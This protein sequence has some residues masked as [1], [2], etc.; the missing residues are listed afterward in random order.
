MPTEKVLK[1]W[2]PTTRELFFMTRVASDRTFM[3]AGNVV[4]KGFILVDGV[5]LKKSVP[6]DQL[7]GPDPK[8]QY[9]GSAV[10][11]V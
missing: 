3:G 9:Q 4:T 10:Y 8:W 5:P 7:F 2:N 11:E 6:P 1:F